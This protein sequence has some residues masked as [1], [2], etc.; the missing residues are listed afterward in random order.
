MTS[1]SRGRLQRAVSAE[2]TDVAVAKEKIA[3][4]RRW[5]MLDV[6][7]RCLDGGGAHLN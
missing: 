5:P 6:P 4:P 3:W 1:R 7:S 2:K